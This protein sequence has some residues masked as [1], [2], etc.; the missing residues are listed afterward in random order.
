M[1]STYPTD[2]VVPSLVAKENP[3]LPRKSLLGV[4]IISEPDQ[5]AVPRLGPANTV[6]VDV[7]PEV[8]KEYVHLEELATLPSSFRNYDI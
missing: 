8:F 4:Y 7:A 1:I 5:T 6:L 3:S 2:K